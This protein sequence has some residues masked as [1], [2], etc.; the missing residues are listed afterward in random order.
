MAATVLCGVGLTLG[1][2]SREFN[3]GNVVLL[4]P[5]FHIHSPPLWLAMHASLRRNAPIRAV[6]DWLLE[7]LPPV[8]DRTRKAPG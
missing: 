7:E 5:E 1:F 8:F 3:P 2:G 6:W 4:F